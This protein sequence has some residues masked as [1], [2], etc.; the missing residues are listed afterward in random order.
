MSAF[1]AALVCAMV[2]S[3]T[4]GLVYALLKGMSDDAVSQVVHGGS[5]MLYVWAVGVW[6]LTQVMGD[7]PYG[8]LAPTPG[9]DYG[10]FGPAGSILAFPIPNRVAW[11]VQEVPAFI[12]PL[13]CLAIAPAPVPLANKV[14]LGMF[15]AHYF[16]RSFI[17]SLR[18]RGTKGS[19]L[20]LTLGAFFFCAGN[21]LLQGLALT[22]HQVFPEDHLK[23][24][25]F[26]LGFAAWAVGAFINIQADD[27]LIKLRKPGETGYKIPRGGMF[28]HISGAN[29][30]GEI[31]EWYGWALAGGWHHFG[32]GLSF[33]VFTMFNIA[34]RACA[35]HRWYV[36]KFEDYPT[37]RKR[38]LPFIF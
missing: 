10:Y 4:T 21:G 23:S 15:L 33:A 2:A 32:T 8:K 31:L 6:A 28:E 9:K 38:L 18:I 37:S 1:A 19:P 13:I 30:V 7:Y 34:P 12:V 3:T 26:I 25:S 36:E 22:R 17:Y 35:T 11:F 27:I 14:V 5:M 24:S 16:Q 20:S 29:F